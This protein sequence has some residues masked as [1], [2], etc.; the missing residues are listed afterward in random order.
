MIEETSSGLGPRGEAKFKAAVFNSN[1]RYG[2]GGQEGG[3]YSGYGGGEPSGYREP[4]AYDG[5]QPGY[6]GGQSQEDVMYP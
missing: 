4:S 3:D 6:G 5:G 2:G 1:C